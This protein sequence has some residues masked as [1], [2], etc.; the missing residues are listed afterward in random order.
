M[1]G[2]NDQQGSGTGAG[3]PGAGGGKD[4]GSQSPPS[5]RSQAERSGSQPAPA[6][7]GLSLDV[8]PESLR[9]LPAEQI[10]LALNQMVTGL[11]RLDAEIR[12]LREETDR[13]KTAPAPQ[14]ERS[15]EPDPDADT[16]LEELILKDPAKA[17]DRWAERKFG[18]QL[19]RLDNIDKRVASTELATVARE[20]DDFEEYREEVEALL[21]DSGAPA[22]K[23]HIL[24]AYTLAVGKRT[25][26]ERSRRGR[27]ELNSEVPN[28][29]PAPEEKKY[30]KTPLS[31]EIRQSL[32][33]SEEA[34]Y[35]TFASKDNF[36]IKVPT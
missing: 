25:L 5:E 4:G 30:N 27:S 24:G 11:P 2:I 6:S 23:D 17:L 10:R 22:T 31:E 29:Q 21:R 7:T 18:T 1:A 34:Y 8:I 13:L 3:T 15:S 33:M 14:P 36:Q 32:R 28:N 12:R 19:S 26:E 35:D 20:I 16:P 9:G